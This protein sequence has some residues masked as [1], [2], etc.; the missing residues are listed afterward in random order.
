NKRLAHKTADRRY[1]DTGG[2]LTAPEP[3][4]H[5]QNSRAPLPWRHHSAAVAGL[6][7]AQCSTDSKYYNRYSCKLSPLTTAS[8]ILRSAWM[9]SPARRSS[10]LG[11]ARTAARLASSW[12]VVNSSS[13]KIAKR[14]SRAKARS[15]AA[16][17]CSA[18]AP[19]TSTGWRNIARYWL[20]DPSS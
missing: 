19:N 17:S 3:E 7:L 12:P 13:V 5:S 8:T 20:P 16:R 4:Q 10:A 14:R 18:V 6:S 11:T 9:A 1:G 2:P 15:Y